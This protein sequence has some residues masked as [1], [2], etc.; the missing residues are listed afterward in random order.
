MYLGS[1]GTSCHM[2]GLA[3]EVDDCWDNNVEKKG[4]LSTKTT[5]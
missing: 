4:D 3:R 5:M 2:N 1:R